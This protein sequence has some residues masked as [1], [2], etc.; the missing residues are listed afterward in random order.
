MKQPKKLTL[1]HKKIVKNKG[2]NPDNWMLRKE[3]GG[4]LVIVH[5]VSGKTRVISMY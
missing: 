2:L 3:D 4:V 5:K 1:K